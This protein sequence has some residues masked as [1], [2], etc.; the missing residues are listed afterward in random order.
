MN[1]ELRLRAIAMMDE[2]ADKAKALAEFLESEVAPKVIQTESTYDLHSVKS[3][4]L[5]RIEWM[6][7]VA[8]DAH[9]D[10]GV[11]MVSD[12]KDIFLLN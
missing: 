8:R 5:G 11:A 4:E 6:A 7:M 10:I 12:I 2:V 1:E 9:R 3:I